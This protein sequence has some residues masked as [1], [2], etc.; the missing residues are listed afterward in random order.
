MLLFVLLCNPLKEL[1]KSS[2]SLHPQD[3]PHGYEW[4]IIDLGLLGRGHLLTIGSSCLFSVMGSQVLASPKHA[5]ICVVPGPLVNPTSKALQWM[6]LRKMRNEFNHPCLN[7]C[8]RGCQH[9]EMTLSRWVVSAYLSQQSECAPLHG[10]DDDGWLTTEAASPVVRGVYADPSPSSVALAGTFT[11]QLAWPVVL[12]L[13]SGLPNRKICLGYTLAIMVLTTSALFSS[14][15]HDHLYPI[16]VDNNK[17]IKCINKN[18]TKISK[19]TYIP[20]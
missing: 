1:S 13:T 3:L 15:F 2:L 17:N 18:K 12:K 7:M 5:L 4:T 11:I 20:Q 19:T 8:M 6:N 10:R 14:N 16:I 9:G